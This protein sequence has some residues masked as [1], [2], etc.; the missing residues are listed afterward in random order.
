MSFYPT[1]M[2]VLMIG[3][4]PMISLPIHFQIE[5][6][7]LTNKMPNM[8]N[9]FSLQEMP[10]SNLILETEVV[11]RS[12]LNEFKSFF[13][14]HYLFTSAEVNM[15]SF[16]YDCR[17]AAK[18]LFVKSPD[19]KSYLFGYLDIDEMTEK[20]LSVHLDLV[21]LTLNV[22]DKSSTFDSYFSGLKELKVSEDTF[23]TW[24]S[25]LPRLIRFSVTR[26][27]FARLFN[28]DLSLL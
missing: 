25:Q 8:L 22:F 10:H 4:N 20:I 21:S 11:I 7:I 18:Y 12:V 13:N 3:F 14:T 26:N 24:L 2:E 28:Y 27:F 16:N 17:R 9:G 5:Y 19:L 1:A 6:K 23:L 15:I